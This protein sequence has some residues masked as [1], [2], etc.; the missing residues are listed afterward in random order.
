MPGSRS[1]SPSTS[2]SATGNAAL[3]ALAGV[4]QGSPALSRATRQTADPTDLLAQLESYNAV[5]AGATPSTAGRPSVSRQ[6]ADPAELLAQLNAYNAVDDG[7][8]T[9]VSFGRRTAARQTADPAELLASLGA[10]QDGADSP[11]SVEDGEAAATAPVAQA[12]PSPAAASTPDS[13]PLSFLSASTAGDHTVTDIAGFAAELNAA[14]ASNDVTP[15]SSAG[16]GHG[17][18]RPSPATTA[19]SDES[20]FWNEPTPGRRASM[21]ATSASLGATGAAGATGAGIAP[22]P[23]V[24]A[25]RNTASPSTLATFAE[26]FAAA[27]ADSPP[28]TDTVADAFTPPSGVGRGV[29]FGAGAG[30]GAQRSPGHRHKTPSKSCLSA[31]RSNRKKRAGVIFGSPQAAEFNF[32]SP[33]NKMTPLT[34]EKAKEYFPMTAEGPLPFPSLDRIEED[35]SPDA[36]EDAETSMNSSILEQWENSYVDDDADASDGTASD[37][38]NDDDSGSGIDLDDDGVEED[39]DAAGTPVEA[40]APLRSAAGVVL[41]PPPATTP[42]SKKFLSSASAAEAMAPREVVAPATKPSAALD[43][44]HSIAPLPS[45]AKSGRRRRRRS[46]LSGALAQRRTSI[47]LGAGA[48]AGAGAASGAARSPSLES[49]DESVATPA[50]DNAATMQLCKSVLNASMTPSTMHDTPTA[51]SVALRFAAAAAGLGSNRRS[52]SSF[53][54]PRRSSVAMTPS[55]GAPTSL[56]ALVSEEMYDDG[57]VSFSLTPRSAK[58]RQGGSTA[59]G[60]KKRQLT[61][62]ASRAASTPGTSPASKRSNLDGITQELGTLQQLLQEEHATHDAGTPATH[63]TDSSMEFTGEYRVMLAQGQSSQSPVVHDNDMDADISAVDVSA[64]ESVDAVDAREEAVAS[65]NHAADVNDGNGDDDEPSL[66]ADADDFQPSPADSAS[67]ASSVSSDSSLGSVSVVDTPEAPAAVSAR[68]PLSRTQS[69]HAADASC[70]D[71]GSPQNPFADTPTSALDEEDAMLEEHRL[72]V[73]CGVTPTKPTPGRNRFSMGAGAV[74]AFPAAALAGASST[75]APTATQQLIDALRGPVPDPSPA[76]TPVVGTESTPVAS[77]ATAQAAMQQLQATLAVAEAQLPAVAAAAA[78]REA[79][80]H[81][82]RHVSLGSSRPSP[83]ASSIGDASMNRFLESP[84]AAPAPG[85]VAAEHKSPS[86][87]PASTSPMTNT[88]SVQS[89]APPQSTPSG[90]LDS[91]FADMSVLTDATTLPLASPSEVRRMSLTSVATSTSTPGALGAAVHAAAQAADPRQVQRDA[92]TLLASPPAAA[93]DAL[94]VG[95]EQDTLSG[96]GWTQSR[97]ASDGSVSLL[98][99]LPGGVA[100]AVDVSVAATGSAVD[101]LSVAVRP[102]D[103]LASSDVEARLFASRPGMTALVT[104]LVES[105]NLSSAFADVKDQAALVSAMGTTACR[106]SRVQQLCSEVL[107]A[108]TRCN[109]QYVQDQRR[110]LWDVTHSASA[111]RLRVTFDVSSWKA[112]DAPLAARTAVLVGRSTAGSVVDE[113]VTAAGVGPGQLLRTIEGVTQAL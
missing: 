90:L 92:A 59:K 45:P 110:L 112:L 113:A 71:E 24:R 36:S 101:V 34:R 62:A 57:I 32:R 25:S 52:L 97:P 56:S 66:E 42:P 49:L 77:R 73:A 3:P 20:A 103:V 70:S 15:D 89:A 102:N 94:D 7:T 80:R 13:V 85:S 69:E 29:G 76:V 27:N 78:E 38:D 47:G 55:L 83:S 2:S 26:M 50:G 95:A 105:C 10:F 61:P 6:T 40:S 107:A 58:A 9:R 35:D 18:A 108:Q 64:E 39:E 43:T 11:Q 65:V 68:E 91:S 84:G 21:P 86:A 51:G 104:T 93:H 72:L 109:L 28:A 16:F 63:G 88:P 22:P 1:P 79:Q 19:A 30:A 41:P 81:F 44:L 98:Y 82:E 100:A 111:T 53:R 96:F 99:A 14:T 75:P 60:S 12:T 33:P 106:L 48:G 54:P 5:A 67:P 23:P 37:N 74:P 17:A 31:Q 87:S 8:T 4:A 46:M